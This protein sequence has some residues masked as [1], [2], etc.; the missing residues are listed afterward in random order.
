MRSAPS[1]RLGQRPR[2][3]Q[4]AH[5]GV[6]YLRQVHVAEVTTTW[7]DRDALTEHAFEPA[8]VARREDEIV[9]V[10]E[11]AD[12]GIVAQS[13]LLAVQIPA[14]KSSRSSDRSRPS[15]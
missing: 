4:R 12:A 5:E 7:E 14:A 6:L 10:G 13:G 11:D 15:P 8:K 1:P 3:T 2:C 9:L